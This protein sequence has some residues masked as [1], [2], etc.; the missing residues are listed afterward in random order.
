MTNQKNPL[1]P[2]AQRFEAGVLADARQQVVLRLF[3]SGMSAR[4]RQAIES[5][6]A[7]CEEYLH[8]RHELR[9]IDIYQ[10]PELAKEEQLVAAPT[11]IRKFPLPHRRLVGSLDNP[12]RFL[13]LIGV[14]EKNRSLKP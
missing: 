1:G 4:S 13:T 10:Q 5:I 3:V 12:S 6:R 9:I 2:A 8:G 11:L 7:L 14:A